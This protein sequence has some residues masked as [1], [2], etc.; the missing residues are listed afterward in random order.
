MTIRI[1]LAAALMLGASLAAQ[2]QT[3]PSAPTPPA[4][5]AAPVAPPPPGSATAAE[6]K[7]A[8]AKKADAKKAPPKKAPAK[9]P[10]KDAPSKA[11]APTTA[12][13]KGDAT[14]KT[15][16]ISTGPSELRDKQG[17]VIPTDPNAYPIDSAMPKKK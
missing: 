7:K 3:A 2:A 10:P 6:K 14:A 11:A 8:D 13:K 1:P 15:G 17:N 12:P 16:T 9:S 4:P 5:A